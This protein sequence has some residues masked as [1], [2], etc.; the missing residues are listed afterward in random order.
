MKGI[1]AVVIAA[2]VAH[3]AA[4][5]AGAVPIVLPRAGQVG[6]GVQGQFGTL[7][8][9]GNLGKEFG[10]GGTMAVRMVYRMRFERAIGLSFEGLRYDTRHETADSSGAFPAPGLGSLATP[11]ARKSLAVNTEGLD[12][13]QFFG[14]RTKTHKFLD[15]GLGI[16]QVY[17][18][19]V[20]GEIVYP[21]VPDGYYM[22]A[23]AGLERFL[24]RSWALEIS[25]RY[26]AVLLDG[27]MNNDVHAAVGVILYAAY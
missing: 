23:G 4:N 2:L 7:A 11:I 24:Y 16:A 17:A 27:K 15:A 6:F 25:A 9:G 19:Q 1:L 13:Y 10:N 22:S 5:T 26:M 8:K 3:L 18:K 12:I 14:T 20:D 21:L